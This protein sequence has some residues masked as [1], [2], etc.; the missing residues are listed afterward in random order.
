M[1]DR[2]DSLL[3]SLHQKLVDFTQLEPS[4]LSKWFMHATLLF[5]AVR[6]GLLVSNGIHGWD[7]VIIGLSPLVV[8]IVIFARLMALDSNP[9]MGI[10]RLFLVLTVVLPF[11][12]TPTGISGQLKVMAEMMMIYIASCQKP[13]PP[14]R[15]NHVS[16]IL[17]HST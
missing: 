7:W 12:H 6:I 13:K 10:Y 15:K 1:L 11:S 14:K 5:Y 8:G 2:L 17:H 9:E 16:R 4:K 3:L